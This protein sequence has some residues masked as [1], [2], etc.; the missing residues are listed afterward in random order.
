M[1]RPAI[2]KRL[3]EDHRSLDRLVAQLCAALDERAIERSF[4][5]LDMLWA[6][7]AVHIRAEH[8]CLFPSILNA[9]S[10]LTTRENSAVRMD[11]A[12]N[13]INRLRRDHDFFMT[14]LARAVKAM[15]EMEGS[16]NPSTSGEQLRGVQ[17][18]IIAVKARL[19]EHNRMEEEMV[20]SWPAILLDSAQ[21]A[22]V[23]DCVRRELENMPPRFA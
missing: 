21:Q 20:Y 17:Q 8:L 13:T 12:Q 9:T 7:L 23:D 1:R 10:Q 16:R 19:E 14:E 11:E 22:K 3:E 18:T 2:W 5:Q 15:R 4:N 6:R